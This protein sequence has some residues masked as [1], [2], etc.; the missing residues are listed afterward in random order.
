MNNCYSVD[1][2]T[3]Y[4]GIKKVGTI[5]AEEHC[6]S[7]IN[8]FTGNNNYIETLKEK[9]SELENRLDGS[10]SEDELDE[11][12]SEK[13]NDIRYDLKSIILKEYESFR[14]RLKKRKL[15]E[16]QECLIEDF[17]EFLE[18]YLYRNY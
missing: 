15:T 13:I 11:E 7:Y 10:Y 4:Y 14:K 18:N 9:I 3:I 12:I 2:G 16:S 17:S 6:E 5:T 1:N 8:D